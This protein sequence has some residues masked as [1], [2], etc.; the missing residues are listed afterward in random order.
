MFFFWFMA[1][2]YTY[3]IFLGFKGQNMNTKV[4]FQWFYLLVANNMASLRL[5]G[6]KFLWK[7]GAKLPLYIH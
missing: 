3:M 7:P 2:L 5:F 1:I 4:L 6:L